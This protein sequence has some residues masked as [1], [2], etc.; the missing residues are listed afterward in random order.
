[1]ESPCTPPPFIDNSLQFTLSSPVFIQRLGTDYIDLYQ[2]HWPDRY[3]PMFGDV[4][5]IPSHSFR[6]AVPAEEQLEALGRAVRLW[7]GR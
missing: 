5:F 1:M 2:I 6:G 4:D 3:V 7:V